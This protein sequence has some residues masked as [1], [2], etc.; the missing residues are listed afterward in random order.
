M[1]TDFPHNIKSKKIVSVLYSVHK[2][3][4]HLPPPYYHRL[5]YPPQS[6]RSKICIYNWSMAHSANID[7]CR[8]MFNDSSTPSESFWAK[9]G[10]KFNYF[11]QLFQALVWPT[12][13]FVNNSGLFSW[14]IRIAY[15]PWNQTKYIAKLS[16]LHSKQLHRKIFY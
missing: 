16:A 13:H 6:T 5:P 12:F 8:L 11:S 4:Y 14:L 7:S 15:C 9:K 2:L 10:P 1:G 3:H